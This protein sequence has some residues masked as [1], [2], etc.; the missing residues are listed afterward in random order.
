MTFPELSKYDPRLR[1]GQ[2]NQRVEDA[3]KRN[4]ERNRVANVKLVPLQAAGGSAGFQPGEIQ[5]TFGQRRNL[6]K[7]GSRKGKGA[8]AEGTMEFSW[9]PSSA[10]AE[11]R[12]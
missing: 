11:A 9:V 7:G 4:R 12:P 2:K 3:Y 8:D 1:P 6:S 5:S 10:E